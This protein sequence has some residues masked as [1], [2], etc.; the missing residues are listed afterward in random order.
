MHHCLDVMHIKKNVCENLIGTLLNIPRKAKDGL[1][2]CKDLAQLGI[3]S[4]LTPKTDDKG[5]TYLPF[6][7]YNL[8]RAEKHSFYII[9]YNL[10]VLE[11]YSSNFR[12]CVSMDKLKL[13]GLKSHDFHT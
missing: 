13:T 11:G 9:L 6:A 12:N 3:R 1:N 8:S 4:E 2:A 10:K 7:C 5:K